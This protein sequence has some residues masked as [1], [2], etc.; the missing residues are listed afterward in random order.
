M[1]AGQ[2][3]ESMAVHNGTPRN[4]YFSPNLSLCLQKYIFIWN[5]KSRM[6]PLI[7]IAKHYA[8]C[9]LLGVYATGSAMASARSSAQAFQDKD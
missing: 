8:F 7:F 1:S 3:N 6:D 5:D 9:P 2:K 4:N